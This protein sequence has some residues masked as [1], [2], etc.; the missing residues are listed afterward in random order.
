[1]PIRR[2]IIHLFVRFTDCKV[3]GLLLLIGLGA[4]QISMPTPVR[5]Q[6][7]SS[8][9]R[10]G[11]ASRPSI[12]LAAATPV[13]R[14]LFEQHCAK[15]H[16][17]DGAGTPAR[18]LLPEIPD[19]T[20]G[21]WQAQRSDPQLMASI[22]DGRGQGM[23]PMRGKI[24]EARVRGLVGYVRSLDRTIAKSGPR[25][26]KG[27]ELVS[28]TERDRLFEQQMAERRRQYHDLAKA[29]SGRAP[30]MASESGQHEVTRQLT[31]S[32]PGAPTFR[33]LF[34][35]RC[36]KCHGADGTGNK[37]RDRLPEIPDFSDT[38]WQSRRADSNLET[39]ILDG[40]G[41]DMP[42]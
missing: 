24:S 15:C 40:K 41:D 28:S 14:T 4:R 11:S 16:G 6:I 1:M 31:P 21:S 29:S 18:G 3:C 38:R 39:S 19:F 36:V 12:P 13:D 17:T 34:A 42:P 37:T 25:Q 23:P 33:E 26:Q 2:Q 30:S 20:E 22:L 8:D 9:S 7:D 5:A 27:S 35:Q 32:T 10:Q